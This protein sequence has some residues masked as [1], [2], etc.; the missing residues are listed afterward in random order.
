[1][2]EQSTRGNLPLHKDLEETAVQMALEGRWQQAEQLNREILEQNPTNVEALNR[3]GKALLELGRYEESYTIYGQT[4]EMEPYNRIARKNRERL[5][6][7]LSSPSEAKAREKE[8]ERI[9]PDLFISESGKSA[10]VPLYGFAP[11][12]VLQRLSRGEGVRL[13]A[14]EQ[15]VTVKTEDGTALGR[16]D[17]RIARRL[18]EFIQAGNRYAAAIAEVN[19]NDV[20]VF[21]R[22]TYQ[23]PKLVGRLSFP[24]P[25]APSEIVR[26]YMRDLGQQLQDDLDSD[27]IDE[28]EEEEDIELEEEDLEIDED[29][30]DEEI[31]ADE[32]FDQ[33]L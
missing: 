10:V 31:L 30:L 26:P 29:D 6:G 19:E 32:D 8:R 11:K 12:S 23:H 5:A 16:L 14:A 28:E 7:L 13:E 20:K 33:D 18:A 9:L 25:S 2:N 24:A 27:L 15:R 3:L 4:L 21:I 17:P 1:M 22:E